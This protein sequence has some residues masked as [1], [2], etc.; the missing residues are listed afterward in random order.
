MDIIEGDGEGALEGAGAGAGALEGAGEAEGAD[1][2]TKT[3][4][5]FPS[6]S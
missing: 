1:A 4:T 3:L 5:S 2:G 6:S